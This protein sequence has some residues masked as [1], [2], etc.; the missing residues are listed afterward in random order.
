MSSSELSEW[1][2]ERGISLR[3]LGHIY[4]HLQTP[5]QRRL[6]MSEIAARC[7]KNLMRKTIQDIVLD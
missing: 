2:H 1:L 4:Q 6:L 3:Y 7:C 5:F